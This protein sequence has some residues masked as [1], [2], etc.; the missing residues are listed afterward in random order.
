[1]TSKLAATIAFQLAAAVPSTSSLIQS[2][3]DTRLGL[4]TSFPLGL[5][6]EYLIYGPLS[7]AAKWS[8]MEAPYLIVI[9]GLDE[10]DEREEV[11]T[12]I[13]DTIDYFKD[14]PCLPLRI[15]ITS[16]VEEHIRERLAS[17]QVRLVNLVDHAPLADIKLVMRKTFEDEAR[18]SRLLKSH[19]GQWPAERD[20][21]ALVR[22]TDGSFIFMATILK[23]IF[24]HAS[25]NGAN[26][27]E[28]LALALNI[29]PGLDGLYT[30]TLAAAE[31]L[32][33]F[34]RI[35]SAI[36]LLSSPLSISGIAALLNISR[37]EVTQAL[38]PLQ[39]IIHVP[40]D[41]HTPVTLCHSSLYDYLRTDRRSGRF[42]PQ[43]SVRIHIIKSCCL[44]L[45]GPIFSTES[46]TDAQYLAQERPA[47]HLFGSLDF[48]E[49]VSVRIGKYLETFISVLQC[50]PNPEF[51]D[52]FLS[53]YILV[54][55]HRK[56]LHRQSSRSDGW[57][58]ILT[59]SV[60]EYLRGP[61]YVEARPFIKFLEFASFSPVPW[62]PTRLSN[63]NIIE[64]LDEVASHLKRIRPS[65]CKPSRWTD[66]VT[67]GV[68]WFLEAEDGNRLLQVGGPGKV[69][70][71]NIPKTGHYIGAFWLD[72][73][74]S[75][76]EHD[77][78]I[79]LSRLS[80]PCLVE[81]KP[82]PPPPDDS[83]HEETRRVTTEYL[84]IDD[85][86]Q[87][88]SEKV[89]NV[90]AIM[91]TEF[92]LQLKFWEGAWRWKSTAELPGLDMPVSQPKDS[93]GVSI[94]DLVGL[95]KQSSLSVNRNRCS[96]GRDG[97]LK[98]VYMVKNFGL[99][100]GV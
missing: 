20:F 55:R 98:P 48:S 23:F 16:R 81:A 38:L 64:F 3:V 91:E 84:E 24:D 76:I 45:F 30:Q 15:L 68:Q 93:K 11:A 22:H 100:D 25:T 80:R 6:F 49:T 73:L 18:S 96:D 46:I 44:R 17:P 60:R 74:A 50:H 4:L 28:R 32:P 61:Y 56:N 82:A 78:S 21:W 67:M 12:W 69:K 34:S 9:D 89:S 77:P 86:R 87:R 65:V 85:W 95:L 57:L 75:A 36:A 31:H 52:T 54:M 43:P 2:A 1:M 5:Q 37:L 59:Y 66:L 29:D 53:T 19:D 26:P 13:T 39:S 58:N 70:V 92:S 90:I 8:P 79:D 83:I 47:Y 40:G 27:I 62:D 71:S 10:C 97:T 7:A 63:H 72:D 99:D 14:H 51:C 33:H 94:L 35:I 41:D 88:L 42:A